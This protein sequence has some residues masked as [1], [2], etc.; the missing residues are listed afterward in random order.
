M[1]LRARR[2][3]ERARRGGEEREREERRTHVL[4]VRL[5]ELLRLDAVLAAV[6]ARKVGRKVGEAARGRAR[7]G[8]SVRVAKSGC[9]R[10]SRCAEGRGSATHKRSMWSSEMCL[11]KVSSDEALC[12][13]LCGYDGSSRGATA[14]WRTRDGERECGAGLGQREGGAR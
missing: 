11:K 1:E 14:R 13:I 5:E 2:G 9:A 10:A 3:S 12:V 7:D 8:Q 6:V 4:E